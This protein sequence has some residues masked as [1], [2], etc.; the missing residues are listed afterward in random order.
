MEE[1]LL[2]MDENQFC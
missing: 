2:I 1:N